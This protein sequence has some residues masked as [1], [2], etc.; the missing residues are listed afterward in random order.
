MVVRSDSYHLK[1][2]GTFLMT[3]LSFLKVPLYKLRYIFLMI[4]IEQKIL[5]FCSLDGSSCCIPW[6]SRFKYT[7]WSFWSS[8][9]CSW[10]TSKEN[11][12]DNFTWL[13]SCSFLLYWPLKLPSL[14]VSTQSQYFIRK[15]SLPIPHTPKGLGRWPLLKERWTWTQS[16][17]YWLPPR[18]VP[19][20]NSCFSD[21]SW[22]CPYVCWLL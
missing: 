11:S 4:Y 1:W 3:F 9:G 2:L 5:N 7:I 19:C 13:S 6:L 8:C 17:R 20:K 18:I 22:F 16:S 12:F 15:S 10:C 21:R 14:F